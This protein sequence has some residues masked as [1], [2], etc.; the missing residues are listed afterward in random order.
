MH[1]KTTSVQLVTLNQP[2]LFVNYISFTNGLIRV[3]NTLKS[4][5]D[6]NV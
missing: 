4:W 3:T 1:K 6:S 2:C 5:F